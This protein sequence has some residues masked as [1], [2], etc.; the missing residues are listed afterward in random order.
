MSKEVHRLRI[1]GNS[2]KYLTAVEGTEMGH[3]HHHPKK[4]GTS[5][6]ELKCPRRYSEITEQTGNAVLINVWIKEQRASKI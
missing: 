2:N 3:C 5:S 1:L 6:E 4:S